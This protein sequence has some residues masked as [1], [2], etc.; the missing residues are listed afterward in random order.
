MIFAVVLLVVLPTLVISLLQAPIYAAHA[1]VLV[2]AVD[3]GGGSASRRVESEIRILESDAVQARVREQFRSAPEATGRAV[4]GTDLIRVTVKSA[5][6]TGAATVANAH[7]QAYIEHR[8]QQVIDNLVGASQ[9]LQ[10]RITEVERQAAQAAAGPERDA[11]N[12]A[13]NTLKQE[14]E[15]VRSTGAGAQDV[16]QL[17]TPAAIPSDPVSPRPLRNAGVALA[18][19]LLVGVVT[20]AVAEAL[21]DSVKSK[22]EFERISPSL[23]VLGMIPVVRDWRRMGEATLVSLSQP[24]SAAA[25]SYRTLRTAVQAV[26][27]DRPIRALQITSSTAGEGKTTTVVNLAVALAKGG[28]RVVVVC[29]D[30][31]RPR[32]HDFFGVTNQVGFTSVVLGKVPLTGALQEVRDQPRLHVLAS[33]PLP[34]NPS[35]LLSSRRVSEVLTTLQVDADIVLIDSPPVLPV[36]DALVLSRHV[37]ATLLVCCLRVA[38]HREVARSVE[39]LGQVGAPLLGAVIGGVTEESQDAY[40]HGYYARASTAATPARKREERHVL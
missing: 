29:C 5:D 22:A 18:L 1:H 34:P 35:E 16:A 14:L 39:L 7:A 28:Q 9:Q 11:L 15:Q 38:T 25:E 13:I 4:A 31:R 26:A 32:V 6:P 21:D 20:A 10:R 12:R 8:R 37:D 30:L 40:G 24:K 23:P 19:G 17:V 2:R 36:T 27:L 3:D 33:G